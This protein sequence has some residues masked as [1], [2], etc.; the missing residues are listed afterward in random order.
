MTASERRQVAGI[1]PERADVIIGGAV[2]LSEIMHR[3]GFTDCLTSESDI[4]DGL[5]LSTTASG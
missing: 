1:E 2:V 4:L 5:I 3:F